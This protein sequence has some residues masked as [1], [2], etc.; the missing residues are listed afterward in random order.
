MKLPPAWKVKRELWRV[1]EQVQRNLESLFV[2]RMRQFFYDRAV[3][4]LVRETPGMLPI[5]SRVAVFVIFQPHGLAPSILFTLEHLAKE[6]W[7]V[8]VVSNAPLALADRDR[9]VP[10]C[11]YLLERPNI[12]YDFGAYREG[13]RWLDRRK[14]GSERR[15]LMNDSTWFPLRSDDDTLRRMEAGAADLAGHVFKTEVSSD[16]RHDHVESHLLMFSRQAITSPEIMNF[17]SSYRMS[18]SKAM[19]IWRGEKGITATALSAGLKVKGQLDR[20]QI[21]S[22]LSI[23]S[24]ADL[25]GVAEDLVLHN[26]AGRIFREEILKRSQNDLLWRDDFILWVDGELANSRQHLV[27]AAFI[28]AA[29][30]FGRMGFIKKSSEMR[31]NLARIA[32]MKAAEEG[33]VP[34]LDPCIADEIAAAIASWREPK[35]KWAPD[36]KRLE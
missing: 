23:M 6:N 19:T 20:E 4:R 34:P 26:Q 32:V 10:A 11:S 18:N 31:F 2:E 14:M 8:L 28:V 7:S 30:V 22:L 36:I 13:W 9:L 17:W 29:M 33:K 12:G 24:D 16:P 3:T 27:S 5:T 35:Q 15:I 21:I 1:K 25:L